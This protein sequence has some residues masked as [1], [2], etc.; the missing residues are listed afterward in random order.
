MVEL[1]TQSALVE[2][3]TVDGGVGDPEC[4]GGVGGVGALLELKELVH[5]W[6]SWRLWMVS[7]AEAVIRR[8]SPP[9]AGTE[10]GTQ[11]YFLRI[12]FVF[13]NCTYEFEMC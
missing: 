10:L 6:W 1:E 5:Y 7:N 13:V 12:L 9:R 11:T 8:A 2:L 3:E 4:I